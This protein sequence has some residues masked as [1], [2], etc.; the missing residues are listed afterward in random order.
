MENGYLPFIRGTTWKDG[1]TALTA[2]ANNG[3]PGKAYLT[4]DKSAPAGRGRNVRADKELLV[5]RN[6]TAAAIKGGASGVEQRLLYELRA[7]S[8]FGHGS[9]VSNAI[10]GRRGYPI[11]DAMV[12]SKAIAVGDD[13]YFVRRGFN[14]VTLL[15]GMGTCSPGIT[16]MIARTGGFAGRHVRTGSPEVLGVF[17]ETATASAGKR[18]VLALFGSEWA[19][20]DGR[21]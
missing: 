5:L 3:L 14:R 1:N 6:R 11:D 10:F 17:M 12:T 13:G 9:I 18:T 4:D 21:A 20:S 19:N 16:R 7:S 8:A 2:G 15:T